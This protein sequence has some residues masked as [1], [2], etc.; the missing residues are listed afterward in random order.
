[1]PGRLKGAVVDLSDVP[2]PCLSQ[3]LDFI[4][5]KTFL[6]LTR[7]KKDLNSLKIASPAVWKR[8]FHRDFHERTNVL[9]SLISSG[10]AETLTWEEK[11]FSSSVNTWIEHY[12]FEDPTN[13]CPPTIDELHLVGALKLHGQSFQFLCKQVE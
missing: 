11:Y 4:D 7:A 1:M 8:F 3:V 9:H 5:A 2:S 12:T 6:R 13:S 10:G